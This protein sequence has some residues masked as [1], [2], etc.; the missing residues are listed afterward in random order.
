[1]VAAGI[2]AG[3]VTLGA[4][5]PYVAWPVMVWY[6]ASL[7]LDLYGTLRAGRGAISRREVS[8]PFRM[9]TVRAGPAAAAATQVALEMCL[10]LAAAPLVLGY[11]ILYLPVAAAFCGAAA[12][13]HTY[14]FVS[15]CARI[16][17]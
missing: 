12:A 17:R 4:L 16:S 1:L 13:S 7:I 10:A 6:G 3:S 9:V 8:V 11:D 15:N 14:G 2:A 5:P